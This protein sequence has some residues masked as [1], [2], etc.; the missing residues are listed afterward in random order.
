MIF[1]DFQPCGGI[2]NGSAAVNRTLPRG[3]VAE[4]VRISY[5][6]TE[7]TSLFINKKRYDFRA[8]AVN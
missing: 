4:A 2:R 8:F 1:L 6:G 3:C 5:A 7:K